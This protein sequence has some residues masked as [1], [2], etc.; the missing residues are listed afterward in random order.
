MIINIIDFGMNVQEAGDWSRIL[1]QGS[2]QPTGT[3]MIDGGLV[4]L[5]Q[6]Y[7]EEVLAE[8]K[9]RGHRFTPGNGA[10]GG[11]QGI[12]RDP[13]TGVYSGASESRK[14]GMAAGY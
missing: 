2:S 14:D 4:S 1:H 7:G 3:T 10:F 13:L 12:M 6:G 8:L 5:E 9:K 11:Y